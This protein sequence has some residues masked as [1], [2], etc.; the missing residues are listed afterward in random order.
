MEGQQ[1]PVSMILTDMGVAHRQFVHAGRVDT[2]E[3]AAS[4]RDQLPEQVIRSLLFRLSDQRFIMVL[5]GGSS[6]VSWKLLRQVLGE[7]RLTTADLAEL[8]A[9]TGY[10]IGA[11]AP[12]GI[13]GHIPIYID[14]GVLEPE[15]ISIGSGVRGTAIILTS[16]DLR[17]ALPEAQIVNVIGR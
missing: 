9:V 13:P 7:S 3:Q 10:E 15:E 5:V 8:K 2:L 14:Q 16:A 17:K 12:F 6:Q 11:V 1:T 4:E